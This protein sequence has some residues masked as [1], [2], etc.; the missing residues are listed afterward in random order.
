MELNAEI[1]NL[2]LQ[3]LQLTDI[4]AHYRHRNDRYQTWD[5][6]NSDSKDDQ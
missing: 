1:G 3:A 5:Q 6:C 2:A 4:L